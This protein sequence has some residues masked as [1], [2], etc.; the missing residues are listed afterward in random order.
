MVRFL[1]FF[2][3][4]FLMKNSQLAVI[5]TGIGILAI[6]SVLLIPSQ[7]SNV[8]E[9]EDTL[10]REIL[11][12]E[13]DEPII[14]EAYDTISQNKLEGKYYPLPREWQTSGPFQIDR[15][16]YAIGE[17]I[18]LR[19]GGLDIGAKGEVAVMRPVNATHHKVYITIPFDETTKGGFNYYVEPQISKT[20]GICSVD[21]LFGTWSL[22]FRGT[23]YPN[24]YFDIID[25]G[26]V[27]GTDIETVC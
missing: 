16:E 1:G 15:K 20:R 9:V 18:F 4:E 13:N 23:N 2:L 5:A 24:L 22:V 21:D 10:D 14:E 26:A 6:V 27:P 7:E 17:K 11:P 3:K 19:I 25:R 12:V 8:A